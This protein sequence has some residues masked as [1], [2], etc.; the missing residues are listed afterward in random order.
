[1]SPAA[2]GAEALIHRSAVCSACARVRRRAG[3]SPTS[4]GTTALA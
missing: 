1:M 4:A 3:A 2:K